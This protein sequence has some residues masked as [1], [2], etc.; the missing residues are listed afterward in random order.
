LSLLVLST[1]LA[2]GQTVTDQ[3]SFGSFNIPTFTLGGTQLWTDHVHFRGWRIQQNVLTNHFR[4]IDPS[5]I[6]RAWGSLEECEHRLEAT[7]RK[8]GLPPHSGRVIILVH[9]LGRTRNAMNAIAEALRGEQEIINFSY[10]ST[11]ASLDDHARAL[12]SVVEHLPGDCEVDVVAHS[13]GCLVVRRWLF[14]A[15]SAAARPAGSRIRRIVMLG[16]PNNGAEFARRL[17]QTKVF[18]VVMGQSANQLAE[19]KAS[20]ATL[21]L[22]IPR[23]EFGIIAGNSGLGPISNPLLSGENDFFVE[24]DETKLEGA[25]D[26]IVMP[27]AHSFLLTDPAVH[28]AVARF[29][30]HGYFVSE[31]SRQ[32]LLPKMPELEP[33]AEPA[34]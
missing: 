11:R 13:L 32:R 10:A 20:P 21:E 33:A 5:N 22:A 1:T 6:R 27:V 3:P 18:G 31:A 15:D 4:L 29:L 16:P 25:A 2:Q 30:E 26:F 7:Q 17:K 9:G 12:Q 34:K 23:G 24:V 19:L 28:I 8:L 14:N